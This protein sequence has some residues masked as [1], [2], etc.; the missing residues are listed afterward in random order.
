MGS[1]ICLINGS[2]F[3]NSFSQFQTVNYLLRRIQSRPLLGPFLSPMARA[4]GNGVSAAET[5]LHSRARLQALVFRL[6]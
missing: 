1:C 5:L 3:P 6:F 4:N 2:A